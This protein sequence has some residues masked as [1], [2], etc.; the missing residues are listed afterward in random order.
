MLVV[1]PPVKRLYVIDSKSPT[2]DISVTGEGVTMSRVGV[3]VFDRVWASFVV[4]EKD[5]ELV[6]ELTAV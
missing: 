2:Q 3:M 4:K 6:G 5:G 1:M